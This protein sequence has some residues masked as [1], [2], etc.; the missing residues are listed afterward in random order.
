MPEAPGPHI[1]NV[2]ELDKQKDHNMGGSESDED[3]A[4][5]NHEAVPAVGK[6]IRG[7]AG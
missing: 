3:G 6:V 1:I 5:E 4:L 2:T 7:R